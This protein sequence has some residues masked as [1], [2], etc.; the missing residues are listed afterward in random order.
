MSWPVTV[1]RDPCA[2]VTGQGSLGSWLQASGT[3]SAE[4]EVSSYGAADHRH[5]PH[6]KDF[7]EPLG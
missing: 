7:L 6:L 2:Q 1:A 5:I 3:A 4:A